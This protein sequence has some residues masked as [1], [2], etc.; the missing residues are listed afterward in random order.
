[1]SRPF[2]AVERAV[3]G[4][5][6]WPLSS[7]GSPLERADATCSRRT[8]AFARVRAPPARSRSNR[9]SR[10]TCSELTCCSPP[11]RTDRQP[12]G[13]ARATSFRPPTRRA[14]CSRPTSSTCRRRRPHPARARAGGLSPHPGERLNEAITR[15]WT[16]L[17]GA[18]RAFDEA[19]QTL[20]ARR[21]RWAV[22]ARALASPAVRGA[23]LRTARPA[24]RDRDR[25]QELP[26]LQPVAA[27]PDPPRRLRRNA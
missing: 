16:R 26:G 18:W 6:D 10:L 13:S 2:D 5:P 17:I 4:L 23:P 9:S 19:R 21:S 12:C 24:T 1:M 14:G 15:S 8:S 27:H 20:A 25:R 11:A 22:D 3:D 7:S